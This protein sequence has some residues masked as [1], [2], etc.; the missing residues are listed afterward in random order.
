[1]PVH[2]GGASNGVERRLRG[3]MGELQALGDRLVRRSATNDNR[4]PARESR[5]ATLVQQPDPFHEQRLHRLADVRLRVVGDVVHGE[6]AVVFP[7]DD[8]VD[9]VGAGESAPHWAKI[10]RPFGP[11]RARPPP[12]L[13]AEVDAGVFIPLASIWERSRKEKPRASRRTALAAEEAPLG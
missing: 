13:P 2:G 12:R 9:G 11:G 6:L 10:G 1:M 7:G 5:A 4:V 8:V 3:R